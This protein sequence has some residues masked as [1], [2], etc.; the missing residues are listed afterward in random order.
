MTP[1]ALLRLLLLAWALLFVAV[2]ASAS[3]TTDAIEIACGPGHAKLAPAVE[4]AARDAGQPVVHLVA[5]MREENPRCDPTRGNRRTGAVGLLQ[6]LPRGNANPGKLTTAQLKDP[7]TNL[8]LG[9]RHLRRMKRLCGGHLGGAV[10]LY[11]GNAGAYHGRGK[12]SVDGH[13]RRVLATVARVW[14][15]LEKR[16]GPRT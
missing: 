10:S 11:H 7:A 1:T 9:A 13:A 6:I 14:R 5:L 12:C 2:P 16:R 15:E 4:A 8:L 3:T